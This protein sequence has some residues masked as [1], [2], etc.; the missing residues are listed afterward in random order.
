MPRHEAKVAAATYTKIRLPRQRVRNDAATSLVERTEVP[1]RRGPQRENGCGWRL[2]WCASSFMPPQSQAGGSHSIHHE[3][4]NR[5]LSLC[6]DPSR[7]TGTGHEETFS[8]HFAVEVRR[9]RWGYLK[10]FRFSGRCQSAGSSK[11][12]WS[13]PGSPPFLLKQRGE[14]KKKPSRSRENRTS[15]KKA[16]GPETQQQQ[17]PGPNRTPQGETFTSGQLDPAKTSA[18][19]EAS[20]LSVS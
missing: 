13:V 11:K 20:T 14:A 8:E 12:S 7:C 1:E 9:S 6:S 3:V 10:E 2:Q 4:N 17:P 15:T 18:K 16:P 19:L 5:S